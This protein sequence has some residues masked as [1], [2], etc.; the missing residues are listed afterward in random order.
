[1]RAFENASKHQAGGGPF[2]NRATVHARE[3]DLKFAFKEIVMLN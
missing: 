2:S 1:M 3:L